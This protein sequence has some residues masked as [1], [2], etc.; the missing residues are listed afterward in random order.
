VYDALYSVDVVALLRDASAPTGNGDQF[1]L[2]MVKKTGKPAVLILNKIDKVKNKNSLL[3]LIEWY[4][5]QHD[6]AEVVPVSALKGEAVDN[7]L[8]QL[9]KYLPVAE[10]L[11]I[12][13]EMTDQSL[14]AIVAELV[15]E[16]ILLET[17]D[18]IPYVT[19]VVTERFDESDSERPEIYCAIYVERPSQKAIVIGKQAAKLKK[20][21]IAARRDIKKLLGKPCRLELFVKVREDWRNREQTLNEIGITE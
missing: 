7:L 12:E 21:G 14:R 13:D 3:P 20:I 17:G 6:W 8:A 19:A 4:A 2:D 11:F 18:E 9:I 15:R 1:V 5:K 16:K 10:P